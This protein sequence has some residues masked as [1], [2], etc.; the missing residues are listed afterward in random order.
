M[1]RDRLFEANVQRE[2][3]AAP[4][5]LSPVR[6][7]ML[8]HHC[9]DTD[10]VINA[11]ALIKSVRRVDASD[12]APRLGWNGGCDFRCDNRSNATY[13]TLIDPDSA[14]YENQRP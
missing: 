14:V 1:D 4:M 9:S 8:C 11:L 6:V 13:A 12:G 10:R 3:M 2:F 5:S 7:L